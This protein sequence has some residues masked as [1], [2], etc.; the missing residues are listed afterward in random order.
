MN[1]TRLLDSY[2]LERDGERRRKGGVPRSNEVK[3]APFL[4]LLSLP[5]PSSVLIGYSPGIKSLRSVT[6]EELHLCVSIQYVF[7]VCLH[8]M[9]RSEGKVTRGVDVGVRGSYED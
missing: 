1:K 3:P 2:M 6:T 7:S 8:A 5:L 9:C 4:L